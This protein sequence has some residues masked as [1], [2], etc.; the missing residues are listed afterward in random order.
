[1]GVDNEIIVPFK[2]FRKKVTHSYSV[3]ISTETPLKP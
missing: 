2:F 1:V 3:E